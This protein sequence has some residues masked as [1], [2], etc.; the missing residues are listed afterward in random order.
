MAVHYEWDVEEIDEH[1]DVQ[2]H[3]HSATYAEAKATHELVPAE[4]TN[5]TSRIVL[6]RDDDNTRTGCRAWAYIQDDGKLPDYFEDAHG[7][8]VAKVPKRFHEEVARNS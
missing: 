4:G 8:E 3:Y 1:D 5:M 7:V 2:D 6:V